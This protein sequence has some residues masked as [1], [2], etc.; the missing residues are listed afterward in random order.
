MGSLPPV[1]SKT[2][3]RVVAS[4][5]LSWSVCV[6]VLAKSP[7]PSK[8]AIYQW[9]ANVAVVPA[10]AGRQRVETALVTDSQG[11]VWLSYLDT[12]YKFTPGGKWL[13]WPRKVVLHQSLDQGNSFG[14]PTVLTEMGGDESLAIGRDGALYAAWVQYSY[15]QKHQ[16]KQRVAVRRLEGGA[17]SGTVLDCL[18]ADSETLHDQS[19]LLATGD[20]AIHVFGT[21]IHP[22]HRGKPQLLHARLDPKS[23]TCSRGERIDSV[24]QLP[25]AAATDKGMVVAGPVG[26]VRS[27]DQGLS[28]D[29]GPGMP[30][31]DKL[32]RVAADPRTG[33]IYVTGDAGWNGLWVF[34]SVDGGRT[35][36]RT[37]VVP[38]EVGREWRFPVAHV[39]GKG[40]LHLAWM[41]DRE[42]F[43]A[44]YHAFS[45]D[46]GVTFSPATRITDAEF[47]FPKRAPPPP[48]ATQSGNWVGDYIS[49]TSV[50]E[51]LVVAWSDQRAGPAL[52]TVYVATAQL[53]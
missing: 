29:P 12:E 46:R 33:D 20:G 19:H 49:L 40:R 8:A 18:P 4:A 42:G 6:P 53:K 48:P 5:L 7:E 39:D 31:G 3:V 44:L 52:A 28:F 34:A 2:T 15:D 21:D 13:A 23:M 22:K 27:A 36:R 32:A 35:W 14:P 1:L 50:G 45:E 51:R 43:G 26:Y 10:Q 17:E 16:L 25:Q 30:F 41:D 37:Q 47:T 24:G 11:R 9:S 38:A